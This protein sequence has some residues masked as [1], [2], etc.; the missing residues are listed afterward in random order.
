MSRPQPPPRLPSQMHLR[1]VLPTYCDFYGRLL[2]LT[3]FEEDSSAQKKLN[4]LLS[5]FT[6]PLHVEVL[7]ITSL[8]L[9]WSF[10]T[11]VSERQRL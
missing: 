3:V 7:L 1:A 4:N 5:R 10:F 2:C 9:V 6:L 11:R 8:K